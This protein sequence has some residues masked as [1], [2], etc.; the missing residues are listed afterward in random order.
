MRGTAGERQRQERNTNQ[1]NKQAREGIGRDPLGGGDSKAT[2]ADAAGGTLLLQLLQNA[3]L[4]QNIPAAEHAAQRGRSCS[5]GCG[6]ERGGAHSEE[7]RS[8]MGSWNANWPFRI[9][10]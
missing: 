7:T 4:L 5:R 10:R 1:E 2:E 6:R 8:Q 3:E 9:F